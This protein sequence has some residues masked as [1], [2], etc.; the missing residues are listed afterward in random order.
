MSVPFDFAGSSVVFHGDTFSLYVS[1]D[2]SYWTV[3]NDLP[4][5]I[6][7]PYSFAEGKTLM[8]SCNEMFNALSSK[9]E[10]F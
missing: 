3:C 2:G 8:Y 5:I 4:S 6:G 1:A 10:S 7:G 9:G